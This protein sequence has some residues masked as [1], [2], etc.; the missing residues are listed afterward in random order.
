MSS[1]KSEA[2]K[3]STQKLSEDF[4]RPLTPLLPSLTLNSSLL[5]ANKCKKSH[6]T[7]RASASSLGVW[8]GPVQFESVRKI[9]PLL[10]LLAKIRWVLACSCSQNFCS[11][12]H[13][14]IF[15][16]IPCCVALVQFASWKQ[17]LTL[18]T[19]FPV[20]ETGKHCGT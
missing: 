9:W 18:E 15:V 12:S 13:A 10:E 5:E 17:K 16:K 1:T 14:R 19:M 6:S 20:W 11:C 2:A 8:N 4:K 7:C 3:V